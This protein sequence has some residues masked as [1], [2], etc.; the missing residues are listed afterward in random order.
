MTRIASRVREWKI[1]ML[2][3]GILAGIAIP[4][5]FAAGRN[6][7]ASQ[8]VCD[9]NMIIRASM[10]V[11]AETEDYPPTS[12]WG[13][14]PDELMPYLPYNFDFH[15]RGAT[16]RWRRWCLPAGLPRH[17]SQRILLGLQVRTDDPV[18]LNAIVEVY[19]GRI[20]GLKKNQVTF[21][22]L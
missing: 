10:A 17:P 21:V 7:I 1:A 22:I 18:L 8:V 19:Q 3:V 6:D 4:H 12:A 15:R 16:Y 20:S 11:Y 5:I 13:E 14:V 2:V 9:F